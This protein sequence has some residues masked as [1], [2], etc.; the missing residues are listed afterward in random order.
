MTILEVKKKIKLFK[1][2]LIIYMNI[3]MKKIYILLF[4]L[5]IVLILFIS[6]NMIDIPSPQILVNEEIQLKIQ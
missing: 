3:N 1:I 5:I 4:S 2:L 6:L